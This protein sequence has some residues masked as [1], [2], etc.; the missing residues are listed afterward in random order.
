MGPHCNQRTQNNGTKNSDCSLD[1]H[2]QF[3]QYPDLSASYHVLQYQSALNFLM[4]IAPGPK[5]TRRPQ[6]ECLTMPNRAIFPNELGQVA[7]RVHNSY[8]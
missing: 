8:C 4:Q 6:P 3:D 1:V 7:L 5:K 2:E